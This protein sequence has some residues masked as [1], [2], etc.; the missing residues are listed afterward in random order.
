[1]K[2]DKNNLDKFTISQLVEVA[3]F[4]KQDYKNLEYLLENIHGIS[5]E[6][7]LVQDRFTFVSANA[8]K[9]LGYKRKEWNNFESWKAMVFHEDRDDA[10]SYSS[11]EINKGNNHF[12]EYRM[13]KKNGEVIWV[14]E[15]VS[16]GK[17]ENGKPIKAY[18]FI[19]NVDEQKKA[20]LELA[21]EHT[22]I[23]TIINNIPDPVMVIR[24]DY[25]IS[26]MNDVTRAKLKDITL[27]DSNSPKC[28][29][30]SHNRTTPCGG[31]EHPCPLR[32]VLKSNQ[33]TTVVHNHINLDGTSHYVELAAT[34]LFDD[35]QNCI[36]IIESARN[37]TEY[38]QLLDELKDKSSLLDYQAHHDFLTNLP[39]RVLFHDRLEQ[40]MESSK[41][42]KTMLALLFIDLDHFKNIN[43]TLGHHIGDEVLKEVAYRIKSIIRKKDTLSRLGGDEFTIIMEGLEHIEDASKLATKIVEAIKEP[44]NIGNHKL[45][46]SCSLGISV[47]PNDDP[48]PHNLIKYA[49]AA[50]YQAKNKGRN[51]F[52]YYSKEM[53]EFAVERLAMES[54][55]RQAIENEE[56]VLHYQPQ[57]NGITQ[58][59]LG[60]EALVRWKNSEAELIAPLKF[61]PL[62]E[63]TDLIIEIDNWVMDNAMKEVSG[64]YK[65][66][67]TPGVLSLNLAIKQLESEDYL[68]RL[69]RVMDKYDFKPSWL[70][71]EILERNIMTHPEESMLK[72]KE[73]REL[74]VSIS[75]DDFGTGY[76]SLAY[77]KR[78]DIN[79]LKIDKSFVSDITLSDEGKSIVQAIIALAKALNIE[80][81]AEGVE[82]KEELNFMI[83]NFC[84]NIQGYY[85]SKPIPAKEMRK[86]LQ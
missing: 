72:L 69:K 18:G 60:F 38:I 76:S 11:D 44:L 83:D 63:E 75:I 62:A 14:Q 56:F 77:L 9:F 45:Y 54:K 20:S 26:L 21:H 47:Y 7:D 67:L 25:S 40:G 68:A 42:D 61:I 39:N 52:Q 2:L 84:H 71:L 34:P 5:F 81:I 43:D 10:T 55:L 74:G 51:N 49:D 8:E 13:V 78:F 32:D 19:I 3:K 64:W 59:I 12:M 46:I 27:L 48:E 33:A 36:G 35:K 73:L 23:Q 66:G 37:I 80:I 29:E 53:T 70:K 50:M 79:E 41:R 85:F 28:Y 31:G 65:E 24:N 4:Y 16:L 57:Y 6:F 82:T 15:I 22:F 17:D 86:L 58:E 1:M 30:V